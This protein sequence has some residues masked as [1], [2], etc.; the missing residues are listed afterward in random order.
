M[1]L[2]AIRLSCALCV[3]S[4]LSLSLLLLTFSSLRVVS[5]RRGAPFDAEECSISDQINTNQKPKNMPE[6]WDP[7]V[8]LIVVPVPTLMDA[9][10]VSCMQKA[11]F[12]AKA[13]EVKMKLSNQTIVMSPA[14]SKLVWSHFL[15]F[16]T[17]TPTGIA[18]VFRT[19]ISFVLVLRTTTVCGEKLLGWLNHH[20]CWIQLLSLNYHS[21]IHKW[22]SFHDHHLRTWKP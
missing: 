16:M 19:M 9:Y 3:L 11:K 14:D 15:F 12:L 1:R 2:T 13:W 18:I 21:F 7:R 4:P 8:Q 20:S 22:S 6:T 10:P 17:Y 5:I